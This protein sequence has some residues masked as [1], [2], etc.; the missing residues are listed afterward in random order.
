MRK[1]IDFMFAAIT[2]AGLVLVVIPISDFEDTEP[3]V[4]RLIK[5]FSW[6]MFCIGGLGFVNSMLFQIE[7]DTRK[8]QERQL[9]TL[10]QRIVNAIVIQC[11][12]KNGKEV[13]LSYDDPIEKSLYFAMC[14]HYLDAVISTL[15]C[16]YGIEVHMC[17]EDLDGS[18]ERLKSQLG[19]PLKFC[20]K[21]I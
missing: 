3:E 15:N 12:S 14:E 1:I 7:H 21:K 5:I 16:D 18:I 11:L 10:I 20:T 2:I 19:P 8:K 17:V 9:R 13:G 6:F 4:I